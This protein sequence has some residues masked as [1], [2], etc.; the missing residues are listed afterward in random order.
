MGT[1]VSVTAIHD[2][3]GRLED[4]IGRAF[5]EMEDVVRLLNRHDSASAL[6][7]LN[8]VGRISNPPLELRTVL[9]EALTHTARSGRAFDPTVQPL[10]DLFRS[11]RGGPDGS[12]FSDPDRSGP[13][14]SLAVPAATD[15]PG[16]RRTAEAARVPSPG[17]IRDLMALV[18][19][20]AVTLAPGR[21]QLEKPGMGL[22]LDGIAKGYVV[23]R[24]AHVLRSS[25]LS[26]FLVDGGGDIRC[27]GAREDGLPWRVAVQDP[28]KDGVF[29]DVIPLSNGAVA[30]SGSYEVFFD[31]Q[32]THHHIVSALDGGSP[33]WIQSVSVVAPSTM[34]A[35][36]LATSVFLMDPARGS[37]Y[38]DSLP[39]CACLIIDTK[40]EETRSARWRSAGDFNLLEAETP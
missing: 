16:E 13:A 38:I 1:L 37:A 17:E 27:A 36:A 5:E 6:S 19:P 40:G 25:G 33:Q 9:S 18:D 26:D 10:V 21:I 15:R 20:R 35:D 2:S 7:V 31:P 11:A 3:R 30:T 23:D 4:A 39:G 14:G 12:T 24:M 8:D 32:R 22:T 34:Q 28:K 29:P